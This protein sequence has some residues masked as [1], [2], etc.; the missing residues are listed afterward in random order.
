VPSSVHITGMGVAT[1]SIPNYPMEELIADALDRALAMSALELSALDGIVASGNDGDEGLL[2]PLLRAEA[3]GAAGREYLYMTGG[4]CQAVAAAAS[5]VAS[6]LSA[7]VAVIGWGTGVPV[8]DENETMSADPFF[9]RPVGATPAQMRRLRARALGYEEGGDCEKSATSARQDAAVSLI[10][11]SGE[12]ARGVV[13]L[14]DWRSGFRPYLP[15]PDDLDPASWRREILPQPFDG[16]DLAD[17]EEPGLSQWMQSAVGLVACLSTLRD[18]GA[19]SP[20]W[21]VEEVGPLG[22]SMTAL[23][24]ECVS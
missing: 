20:R 11:A 13:T 2:S 18:K 3:A 24:L 8:V 1:A 6:G 7:R 12:P 9:L 23:A 19:A 15:A 16:F 4:Y 5:I 17:V 10:L 14:T 21:F 22:Q